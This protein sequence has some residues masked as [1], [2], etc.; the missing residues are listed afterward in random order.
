V[1]VAAVLVAVVPSLQYRRV[2]AALA[3]LPLSC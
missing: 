2:Y 3:R 1:A